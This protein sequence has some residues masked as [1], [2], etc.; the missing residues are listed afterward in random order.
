MADQVNRDYSSRDKSASIE[1]L[2]REYSLGD[3][4]PR[5]KPKKTKKH[6]KIHPPKWAK[7]V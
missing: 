5:K 4:R 6:K 2:M 7:D 1:T 3:P